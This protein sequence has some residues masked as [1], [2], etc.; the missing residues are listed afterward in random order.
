MSN[1]RQRDTPIVSLYRDKCANRNFGEKLARRFARQPDA[2]MRSGIIW[3]GPFV[4]AE[5]EAAQPHKVRHLDVINRGAM[6]A[7]FVGND[8]IARPSGVTLP[9]G[10]TDCTEHGDPVFDER[11]M[12]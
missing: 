12:L 6:A 3:N 4:H 7:L 2:T 5:V 8:V 11:N 1:A 9:S 10:R